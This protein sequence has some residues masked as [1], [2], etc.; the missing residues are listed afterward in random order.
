MFRRLLAGEIDSVRY[1]ENPVLTP[2]GEERTLAWHNTVLRDGAGRIVGTL[3]SGE[4]I[5]ER[6]RMEADLRSSEER[7]RQQTAL[8][9][10]VLAHI[11]YF[12]FWKDRDSVYLG[13]NEMFAQ[14]TGLATPDQIV[15]KTDHDLVWKMEAELYR[16]CDRQVMDSG[17]PLLNYEEPQTRGDGR[18]ITLLTSKVPLRDAAG[19]VT[20]ILGIYADITERKSL[21][22]ALRESEMR[23]RSVVEQAGDGFELLDAEGRFVDTNSATCLSLGYPKEEL[24]HLSVPDVNPLIDHEKYTAILESLVGQPPKNF[25]SVHRRKDG[26]TFPVEITASL[27][28]LGGVPRCL[29]LVRDITERK[30]AEQQQTQLLEKLSG[31]NQELKDFAYVVSHD[32]KAP[33]RAIKTLADWLAT[34]YQDK[35]DEQGQETL[36]LMG[37]R[38]HRMQNLIDGVLQYSRIGRSG[39]GDRA[40]RSQP[41]RA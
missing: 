10:N 35:L 16:Q 34:D 15:G 9:K 11:P 7:N 5:T 13:C 32:L 26:T 27:I 33:L 38:V 31:I 8:L 12:V 25:E 1:V 24:L 39:A 30:R 40:G 14:S 17:E 29:S 21:E 28:Q 20:G 37:G 2:S 23:F 41:A 36:R 3:S 22:N 4:D 18:Q 6:K 19:C